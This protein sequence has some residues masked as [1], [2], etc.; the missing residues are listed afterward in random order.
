MTMMAL[1][2]R[3]PIIDNDGSCFLVCMFLG[4]DAVAECS[5]NFVLLK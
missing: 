3:C 5:M 2:L 1:I 4:D